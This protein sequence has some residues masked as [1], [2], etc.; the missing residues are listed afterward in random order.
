MKKQ[1]DGSEVYDTIL[2][3]LQ[4]YSYESDPIPYALAA[5]ITMALACESLIREDQVA[6]E[7]TAAADLDQGTTSNVLPFRRPQESHE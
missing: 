4:K 5:R 6:P 7:D 1:P 2:K 3:I